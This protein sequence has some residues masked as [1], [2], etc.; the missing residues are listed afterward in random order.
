MLLGIIKLVM[1]HAI[2]LYYVYAGGD[3]NVRVSRLITN[4]RIQISITLILLVLFIGCGTLL[5]T[6]V[7][8]SNGVHWTG[9]NS[10][11]RYFLCHCFFI[12]DVCLL[13]QQVP[14]SLLDAMLIT[15]CVG[16]GIILLYRVFTRCKVCKQRTKGNL[17]GIT[18]HAW[19]YPLIWLHACN[20]IF[21]HSSLVC[22]N[23]QK[24][25]WKHNVCSSYMYRYSNSILTNIGLIATMLFIRTS[26][27]KQLNV[28]LRW[29][30]TVYN[31]RQYIILLFRSHPIL[32]SARIWKIRI[33]KA[34]ME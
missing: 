11:L 31:Y 34:L 33:P 23:H 26:F 22:R 5:T 16:I 27:H 18:M 24:H 28:H 15:S 25:A 20:Q 8:I 12:T 9:A 13:N 3:R 10:R 14:N 4:K 21:I 2:I 19:L 17:E 7:I 29:F 30:I 6:F 32:T 1:A